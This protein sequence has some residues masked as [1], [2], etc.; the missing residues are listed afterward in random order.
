MPELKNSVVHRGGATAR[1]VA[2]EKTNIYFEEDLETGSVDFKFSIPASR[3][4]TDIILEISLDDFCKIL[5]E[6]VNNSKGSSNLFKYLPVLTEVVNAVT[7]MNIEKINEL[8]ALINL[9]NN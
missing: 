7:K 3:G 6:L 5:L 2:P 1:Y 4:K 8:Q 9:R